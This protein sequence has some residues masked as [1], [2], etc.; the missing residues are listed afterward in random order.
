M[1]AS[2][3]DAMQHQ[4]YKLRN[5]SIGSSNKLAADWFY[6]NITSSLILDIDG[7]VCMKNGKN[8]SGS[9]NTLTDNTLALVLVFLYVIAYEVRDLEKV[10]IAM[11]RIA[12][13][14]LGD[15]SIFEDCK[16]LARLSELAAH[17]GFDLKPEAA[18]GPLSECTFLSSKFVFNQQYRMWVQLNNY[19][20]AI[21]NVYFNFKSRSWRLSFAKLCQLRM[22][23]YAYE[24]KRKQ[25]DYLLRYIL[26][27][28]D[29]E[30]QSEDCKE[31]T[32][33]SARAQLMS[34]SRNQFLIFGAERS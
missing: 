9:F 21:A 7:N 25:I 17:L 10:F 4:V 13:K 24:D 28:H 33:D 1:E 14:M 8:P 32:Y 15:D 22:I 27:N 6:L 26:E 12:C 11:R 19:A 30:M 18:P 16:E 2:V 20:K 23:F 31:L 5:L 34:D 29:Y 3:S